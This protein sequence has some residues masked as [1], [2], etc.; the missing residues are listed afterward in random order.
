MILIIIKKFTKKN[1]MNVIWMILKKVE[2]KFKKY[3]KLKKVIFQYRKNKED[4]LSITEENCNKIQE[5]KESNE[6]TEN[7]NIKSIN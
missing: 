4:N 7:I 2:I 5:I 1:K 6:S 3:I